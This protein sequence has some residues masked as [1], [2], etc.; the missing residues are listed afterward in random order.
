VT[1]VPES[2]KYRGESCNAIMLHVADKMRFHPVS[3]AMMLIKLV[4]DAHPRHFEWSPYPTHVNPSGEKHLDK[5]LGF[6]NSESFFEQPWD[7]FKPA[8]QRLLDCDGWVS[9]VQPHLL[10]A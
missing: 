10:Y 6:E 9:R 2:G 4:K 7:Q 8:T 3:A 5:L 1:F